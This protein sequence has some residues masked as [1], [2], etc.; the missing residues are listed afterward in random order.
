MPFW[1][2]FATSEMESPVTNHQSQ[3]KKRQETPGKGAVEWVSGLN[4]KEVERRSS[5]SSRKREHTRRKRLLELLGL[6]R[7]LEDERVQVAVA[8]DLELGLAGDG[9]LLDAGS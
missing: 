8:A 6:F 9:A 2:F 4:E 7:V 5:R 3:Q 1:F